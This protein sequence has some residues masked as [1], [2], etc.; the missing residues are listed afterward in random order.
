MIL[1]SV[2]SITSLDV[3]S[4][5]GSCTYARSVTIFPG[6]FI[7]TAWRDTERNGNIQFWVKNALFLQKLSWDLGDPCTNVRP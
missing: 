7:M 2:V 6:K 1:R 5:Q 3:F 4:N